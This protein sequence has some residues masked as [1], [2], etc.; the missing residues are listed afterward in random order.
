MRYAEDDSLATRL[1]ALKYPAATL[2]RITEA[3]KALL[4][5]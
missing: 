3:Y 2:R 4:Q 5:K 1:A